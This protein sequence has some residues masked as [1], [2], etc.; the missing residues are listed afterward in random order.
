MP[1]VVWRWPTHRPSRR[2]Y[3]GGVGSAA[4]LTAMAAAP[5]K[6]DGGHLNL[7]E[8]STP[9]WRTRQGTVLQMPNI[10]DYSGSSS[11]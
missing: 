10:G 2:F 6:E 7:A 9:G 8:V 4:S 5:I 1:P 11:P 3:R